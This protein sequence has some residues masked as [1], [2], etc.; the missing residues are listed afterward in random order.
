MHRE[1]SHVDSAFHRERNLPLYLL[2]G[3]IGL[4]IALDL[5]PQ[6]AGRLGI[7]ALESWPRGVYAYR[8]ALIA[9]VIGGAR[10]LYTSL[11]GLL[12]GKIGADLAIAIACI[13]AILIPEEL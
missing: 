5:V 2:T 8:F 6:V 13:A 12:E 3:L 10:V 4:L 1:I 7:G 11:Q 9:A